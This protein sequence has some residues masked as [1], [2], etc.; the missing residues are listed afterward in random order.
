MA[1]KA[2]GRKR[3]TLIHPVRLGE[4][5]NLGDM[6]NR[7]KAEPKA[8]HDEFKTAVEKG[9]VSLRSVNLKDFHSA[10]KDVQIQAHETDENG[11]STRAIMASAF[12]LLTGLMMVSE[13]NDGLMEVEGISDQLVTDFEDK[14]KV[15]VIANLLTND[16][17]VDRVDEGKEFPEIGASEE[18]YEVLSKRNGRMLSITQEMIEENDVPNIVERVNKLVK[19]ANSTVEEETLQAVCDVLSDGSTARN[20]LLKRGAS[21]A[22]LY[23]ATANTPGTRV[24]SGNLVT[25]NA[26]ASTANLDTARTRLAT[27]RDER[28]KRA[29]IPWSQIVL[30]VPDALL[31]IASKLLNSEL[32]PG[33]ENEVNNWGPRGRW[34]PRLLSTPKLDDLSTTTWFM[35]DFKSQFRRKWKIRFEPMTLGADTERFLRARIAY[36][37]RLAWDFGTNPIDYN[38]VVKN[39]A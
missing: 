15:T 22:A 4:T 9:E 37:A 5:P 14:K 1:N 13:I 8:F 17:N 35:G 29:A 23:S 25:S 24:P 2:E 30:L 19:I 39:T 33:V 21:A 38:R 11:R 3:P 20:G 7:A 32:E 34:R 28:G 18:S 27:F 10:F 6:A 16:V 12:P 36:Q 26:L 31:G